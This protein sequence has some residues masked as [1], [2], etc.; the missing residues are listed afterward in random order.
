MIHELKASRVLI[1]LG[2]ASKNARF[3]LEKLGLL[4]A[5]NVIVDGNDVLKSKPN[6][7]VFLKAAEQMNLSPYHCMVLEDASAGITA[8]LSANMKVI[9]L[10]DS[11]ELQQAH[12]VTENAKNISI[13]L[14]NHI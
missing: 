14:L 9:G 10:G 5:F 12:L 6:P 3:V 1:A 13:E 7:E 4:A 8:A 11:N 2:S